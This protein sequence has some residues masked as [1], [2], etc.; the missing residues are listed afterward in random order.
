[1]H[2]EIRIGAWRPFTA[3]QVLA[4]GEGF[5][6]AA[7][8]RMAGAPVIGYDRYS[9][10]VGQMRWR[11]LGLI[12]VM[13][14]NGEDVTASAAGRLASEG[15]LCPT[16]FQSCRWEA[17]PE[18]NVVSA[19]WHIGSREEIV[20]LRV[21]DDGRLREAW[22]HRWGNPSGEP[23]GSYPFGVEVTAESNF[24]GVRIPS[25]FRVGWWWRTD[26]EEEGE[27]FRATVTHVTFQ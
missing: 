21:D 16:R 24:D 7:T 17:S 23:F 1:M 2:G 11:L 9:S 12:P 27:F 4:P 18:P 14:A 6:W 15:V 20:N 8:A 19:L 13:T 22:M 25:R 3:H 10:G 26:R 5:I